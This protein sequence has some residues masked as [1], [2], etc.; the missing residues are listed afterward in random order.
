MIA[1]MSAGQWVL[2]VVIATMPAS[3]VLMTIGA[4]EAPPVWFVALVLLLGVGSAVFPESAAGLV[5]LVLVLAWWGLGLRDGLH[6]W[7]LPAAAAVLVAHLAGLVA[8]YGP[9]ELP[10]DPAVLAL[11]ARRGAT[12]FLVA[13][14]LYVLASV[15]RD[16]PAPPGIWVLGLA[17]ALL[18]TMTASV[19]FSRTRPEE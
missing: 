19:A 16:S 1:R 15:F 12:V 3:A 7:S 11:W 6:P 5:V 18:A 10:L 4:G 9:A 17:A 8:A 13:P 2:R 14:A